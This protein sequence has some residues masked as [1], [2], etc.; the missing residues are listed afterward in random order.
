MC[1]AFE[2]TYEEG[3]EEG[4]EL[5]RE[6]GREEGREL[7]ASEERRRLILYLFHEKG[8]SAEEIS[9]LTDLDF[10]DVDAFIQKA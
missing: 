6:E 1:Q 8:L 5:G 4:W 3:R 7:G 2:E 10:K 9:G